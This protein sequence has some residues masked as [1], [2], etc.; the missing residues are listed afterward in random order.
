MHVC[1]DVLIRA[2]FESTAVILEK[3]RS[4]TC[5]RRSGQLL[6][7]YF[8]ICCAICVIKFTSYVDVQ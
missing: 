2:H 4:E 3:N 1:A 5:N 7:L 8:S 6:G